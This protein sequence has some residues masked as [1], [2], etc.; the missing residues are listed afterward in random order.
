MLAA[1]SHA[2]LTNMQ[3]CVVVPT[4][5]P[6]LPPVPPVPGA[7]W[8]GGG[9]GGPHT[10]PAFLALP[11]AAQLLGSSGELCI[12]CCRPAGGGFVASVAPRR[13][14]APAGRP[15]A[16]PKRGSERLP[17]TAI[18]HSVLPLQPTGR[19]TATAAA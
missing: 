14:L 3:C 15:A 8:E 10:Q 5:V 6:T 7:A 19:A 1:T 2:V 17:A 16:H 9:G 11:A 12:W 4:G 18:S 13:P